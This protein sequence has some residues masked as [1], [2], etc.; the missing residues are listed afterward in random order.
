MRSIGLPEL[1]VFCGIL[2][3][4]GFG[5]VLLAAGLRSKQSRSAQRTLIDKLPPNELLAL[6]QTP[7]GEKLMQALGEPGATPARSILT[8]IQRGIV[9]VLSGIGMLLAAIFTQAPP[10]VPAIALILIFLGIGLL[11][12][13]FVAYRLSKRWRLLQE[14]GGGSSSPRAD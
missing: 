14:N 12:A 10:V 8:S 11:V 13:A 6:L 2:F 5:L 1:L 4:F 7:Q 9:V 3:L